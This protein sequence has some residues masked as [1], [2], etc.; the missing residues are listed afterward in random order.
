MI[1]LPNVLTLRLASRSQVC[2]F[3]GAKDAGV[4]CPRGPAMPLP[5]HTHTVSRVRVAAAGTSEVQLAIDSGSTTTAIIET[6]KERYPK[7][8][9]L[10]PR[11]ALAVNGE[12][13]HGAEM[14][15]AEGDEVAL[16]P[17]MS[18]G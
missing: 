8:E 15:L 9:R 16:L 7:L 12:Y 2:L 17:P 11:C 13:V 6:L 10:L 18:G 3:A 1:A 5:T 14:P 4:A